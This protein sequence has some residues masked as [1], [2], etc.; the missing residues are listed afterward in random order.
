MLFARNRS[1]LGLWVLLIASAVL[2]VPA[3]GKSK[4]RSVGKALNLEG[5]RLVFREEFDG[6]LDIA[7]WGPNTRWIAHTPWKGDFGD[8]T[9]AD[10]APGFPFTIH[11]GTLRIEA[12]KDPNAPSGQRP[13]RSGL[14]ASNSPNGSGFALQYGYFEIS[15]KL[16]DSKGVWPAFWL[17]TSSDRTDPHSADDG[18]IE[19]DVFEFYGF[20]ESY[21]AVVHVWKPKPHRELG[22]RISTPKRDAS[23]GF[24]TYG[25]L[26]TP[27]WIIFYRDRREVWRTETPKEHKRPLMIL[28]NLALGGGW[29]IY[30]V[31]NPSYMFV[32]YVR[33]YTK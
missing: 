32:D 18:L 29:P 31:K 25:A 15:A 6:E 8:A 11:K 27:E 4:A 23:S 7:A 19:I 24:H 1:T 10:P 13:W 12:R 26:V 9:F 33:A 3:E 16:P 2:V 30:R 5:Y 28:L 20:P 17:S 14:L 22:E 21:H